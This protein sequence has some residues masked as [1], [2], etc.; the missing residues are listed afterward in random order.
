ME[1][2]G[3]K[4]YSFILLVRGFFGVICV[5]GEFSEGKIESYLEKDFFFFR[6]EF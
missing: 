4:L 6:E 2:V 5:F 3:R 1:E